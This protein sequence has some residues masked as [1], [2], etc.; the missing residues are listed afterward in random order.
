MKSWDINSLDVSSS[1][2]VIVS[3]SEDAR[4]IVLEVNEGE[5]L[6]EHS[7][8]ER[9]IV[10]VMSGEVEIGPSDGERVVGGPG[11]LVEFE[12]QEPHEV[13][14]KV[15]SR[16][17]LL[18]TPWPAPGHPGAMSLEDKANVRRRAAEV[19]ANPD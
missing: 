7:V 4:A 16:L 11:L 12:R 10:V 6:N 13:I 2:P 14:A 1:N 9:A 19:A 5:H 8:H 3:S 18:L 15:D 17:L